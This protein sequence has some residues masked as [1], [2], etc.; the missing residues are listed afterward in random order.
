MPESSD[1]DAG[2]SRVESKDDIITL[3]SDEEKK[4][5][6]EVKGPSDKNCALG[7][8][9]SFFEKKD[10]DDK[11][12]PLNSRTKNKPGGLGRKNTFDDMK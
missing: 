5:A 9:P 1:N 7:K 12:K 10:K 6:K 11:T 2:I 4:E 8:K 3:L